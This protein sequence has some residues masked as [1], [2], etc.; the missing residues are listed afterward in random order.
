M[1]VYPKQPWNWPD[2]DHAL[3][4]SLISVKFDLMR[5]V[6]FGMSRHLTNDCSKQIQANYW[7]ID[8]A[9]AY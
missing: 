6:K 9:D 4:I 3:L 2:F 1:L 8:E 7:Y 5:R